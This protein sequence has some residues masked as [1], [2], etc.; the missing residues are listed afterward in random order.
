MSVAQRLFERRMQ[1][2]GSDL[3]LLEIERHQR[4]V[5]LD[6]LVD[7]GAVRVG[8]RGEVGFARRVEKTVDDALA[9]IGGGDDWEGPPA[10]PGPGGRPQPPPPPPFCV[11]FVFCGVPAALSLRR[12]PPP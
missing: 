3:A 11:W 9:A 1:L 7:Q 4:L 10:R 8:N 2:L 6:D 5:D 12:P